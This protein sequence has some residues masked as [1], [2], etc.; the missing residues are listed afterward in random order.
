[1]LRIQSTR[2]EGVYWG[3]G[4]EL[5]NTP[6]GLSYGHSGSTSSGFI[7]NFTF[8]PKLDIGYV[9]FT[10]SEMGAE[11]SIP[12]L[13]QFSLSR[14]IPDPPK[15]ASTSVVASAPDTPSFIIDSR[16]KS[17]KHQYSN[18]YFLRLRKLR[19]FVDATARRR[20]NSLPGGSLQTCDSPFFNEQAHRKAV[21]CPSSSRSRALPAMLHHWNSIHGDATETQCHG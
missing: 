4:F 1:M 3:L 12:L 5:N 16:N 9:F 2:E 18:I 7:C 15:R 8:F 17:Y 21:I 13:T 10:N 14:P 6:F 19:D 11:L 20:W